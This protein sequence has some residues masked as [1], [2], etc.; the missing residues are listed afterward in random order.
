M[1]SQR[2]RIRRARTEEHPQ[3]TTTAS[4]GGGGDDVAMENSFYTD[5]AT[6]QD[7]L[8]LVTL[9]FGAMDTDHDG[10]ISREEF[11]SGMRLACPSYHHHQHHPGGRRRSSQTA[12]EV[13]H[14]PGTVVEAFSNDN[15]DSKVEPIAT[16]GAAPNQQQQHPTSSLL[17]F[18]SLFDAVDT[19]QN[20]LLT[21]D[22]LVGYCSTRPHVLHHLVSL[23]QQHS[24]IEV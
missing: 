5:E 10:K 13:E 17:M 2:L 7:L 23:F 14:P 18:D 3:G 20:G 4:G 9:C 12:A 1:A 19:D 15:A 21:V 6:D 22:E 8:Y 16:G 11:E 24:L